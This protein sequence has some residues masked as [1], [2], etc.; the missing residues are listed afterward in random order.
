[1]AMLDSFI[2]G[3][4]EVKLAKYPAHSRANFSSS[5]IYDIKSEALFN[6]LT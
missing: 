2:Q 4:R 3:S 5:T 1:M 6:L